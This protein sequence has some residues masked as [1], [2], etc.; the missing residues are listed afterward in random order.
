MCDLSAGDEY[1]VGHEL[2]QNSGSTCVE[3]IMADVIPLL[4]I[5]IRVKHKPFL[6]VFAQVMIS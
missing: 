2:R 1:T 5:E 3:C 6:L 4:R